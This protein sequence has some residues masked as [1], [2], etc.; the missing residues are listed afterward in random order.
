MKRFWIAG[1]PALILGYGAQA[2]PAADRPNVLLIVADDL[3]WAD[4]PAYGNTFHETPSLDRLAREGV[5]FTQFYSG[6]VCSPTRS[7]LQSGRHEAR[8]GITQHIP[9][10]RRPFA[11]LIDPAVPLQ[12]PLEVETVAERLG[13][14]GYAT[15]YFGKWHLG[16]PGYG[17]A[18]Q[19]WQTVLEL[20][21]HDTP[22]S[23]TGSEAKRTAAFLTEKAVEFIEAH[24]EAPFLV[25]VSHYAVHLP[26]STRPELL[27]KY[28][29]KV[30]MP[31]FPSRPDYAGLLE[32][33]DESVGGLLAALD[34][35]RLAENTLVV[36]VS[37]NGGLVHA[38]DG[39]GYTSNAP[40]RGEKGTL[41]EGGIRVPAL[42]RFPGMI[43]P[44]SVCEVPAGTTD[45][46]PTFLDLAGIDAPMK[47]PLD[48][49]SLVPLLKD[50]EADPARDTL[51]WH[52]PHYHHGTPAS[53]IRRGDW[54]LLEFFETGAL[55][56]YDLSA[57]LGETNNLAAKH[58][59][60]T[61]E[62]R[63]VLAIWRKEV[64]ARMP[65]SNPEHDPSRA[66]ELGGGKGKREEKR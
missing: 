9:G 4:L 34:R 28:R 2:R 25:Q 58:P 24:R 7:N 65:T 62:L 43:P 30:P 14:A 60:K 12:L 6:A 42:A 46:P 63:D 3:G 15:G 1:L 49:V 50:S 27:K 45:L 32:E 29:G 8:Y 66:D 44:G 26:L 56:L 53:A 52:L 10:H 59:D 31:G 19:G 20:K 22:A 57:D 17:P 40:L 37:D 61:T 36:F 16:G 33:L 38:Q 39:E 18:Y 54:K 5:R 47:D 11:K 41:Y 48:G 51:F 23:V 55:E 64:G 13:A 35:L 21:G